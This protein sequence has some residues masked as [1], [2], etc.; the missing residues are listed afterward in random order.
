MRP[1]LILIC[2]VGA[3]LMKKLSYQIDGEM[4]LKYQVASEELDALVTVKC[5]ED[6]RYMRDEIENAGITSR[7]RAF[8][9]PKEN[10]TASSSSLDPLHAA[11]EQRYIDAIN[12]IPPTTAPKHHPPILNTV[13]QHNL[14]SSPS[15]PTSPDTEAMNEVFVQRNNYHH[16]GGRMMSMHRVRSSPNICSM[17]T[18]NVPPQQTHHLLHQQPRPCISPGGFIHHYPPA[19]QSSPK[20]PIERRL[21]SVRSVGRA[22]G[23]RYQFDPTASPSPHHY[24]A[25]QNRGGTGCCMGLHYEDSIHF[26][27]RTAN[28]AISPLPSTGRLA[29]ADI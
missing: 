19:Y 16:N 24:A 4:I 8:L 25:M 21:I 1:Y 23:V 22:D 15:S 27:D 28:R 14:F 2:V 26:S 6:V 18:A 12:G 29:R 7:L 13:H 9:F 10:P 5:D 20:P 17:A 3:E 11:V